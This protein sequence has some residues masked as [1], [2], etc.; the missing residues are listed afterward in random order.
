VG[1]QIPAWY[2]EYGHLT[3]ARERPADC[4]ECHSGRLTQDPDVLDTWFSSGLWPFSTFGWPEDTPA[5]RTFY[6][7]S[8]METGFDILFSGR[9]H[10][11]A[12]LHFMG[13][14]PFRTVFLH[15]MVRDEKGE[16]MS[17]TR[18]NVIDP[19]DL[20]AR[21]GADALRFTLASMAGQD[22]T[23]SSPPNGSRDIARSPTRS[24]TPPLCA[25]ERR[26]VRSTRASRLGLRQVDPE[27]VPAPASDEDRR[28]PSTFQLLS[29]RPRV[30]RSG[31]A[32]DWNRL[33]IHL[34]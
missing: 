2:C 3:V 23:S 18:G 26:R 20:T 28:L 10:G 29:T 6:P 12:R 21:Y 24:G 32:G 31:R 27:P 8:V 14:V 34:S 16:K 15:A 4:A 33:R 5:L 22:A 19:L 1:H 25:D 9:P 30:Y 7:N 17:K 13:E 11:H